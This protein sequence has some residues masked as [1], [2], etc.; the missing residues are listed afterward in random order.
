[1]GSVWN[2]HYFSNVFSHVPYVFSHGSNRMTT[3]NLS[4]DRVNYV[5]HQNGAFH[6]SATL[7]SLL[8]K[9]VESMNQFYFI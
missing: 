6:P 2:I 5:R 7:P 1:M 8:V 4:R 9:I 3:Q